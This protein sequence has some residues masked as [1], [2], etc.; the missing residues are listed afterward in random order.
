MNTNQIFRLL[1]K[2][3]KGTFFGVF[4]RNKLPKTLPGGRNVILVI[5]TDPS[6][7]KGSHWICI[8]IGKDKKGEYFDSFGLPASIHPPFEKYMNSKCTEWI[9][10]NKQLQSVVSDVCGCYVVMYAYYKHLNYSMQSILNA[11]T[12]DT[13]L[14]D[15]IARRFVYDHLM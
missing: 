3:C 10:N 14:N 12:S 1:A 9:M 13:G 2:K 8:F 4:A 5:N 11:W 15:E 7:K 6:H